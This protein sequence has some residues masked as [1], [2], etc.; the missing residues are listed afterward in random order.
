MDSK[1]RK[2]DSRQR[3]GRVCGGKEAKTFNYTTPGPLQACS[4]CAQRESVQ[5]K[6][7]KSWLHSLLY[8]R[9]WWKINLH[10]PT[11]PLH[12]YSYF[13]YAQVEY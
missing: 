8:R 10:K 5:R 9:R 2:T 4:Q 1:C 12:N 7:T 11:K 13:M 6:D 3:G